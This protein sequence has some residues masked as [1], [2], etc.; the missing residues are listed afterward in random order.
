MIDQKANLSAGVSK[1]LETISSHD[2]IPRKKAKFLNFMT[3]S[4]RYMKKYDLEEAWQ[5]LEQAM[6]ESKETNSEADKPA[7][8]SPVEPVKN[9]KHK[10][11]EESPEPEDPKPPKKKKKSEEAPVEQ[12]ANT[13]EPSKKK[14][15]WTD[16]IRTII[17]AENNELKLKKL[18][19]KVIAKYKSL[20][21]FDW[22]DKME[23]KFNKKI[24]KIEGLTVSEEKVRLIA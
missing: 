2:N 23:N 10:L 21:G 7:L 16:T 17:T 15:R 14:F 12:E 5:L 6:K 24:G 11:L 22:T 4:F 8:A 18:K 13:T 20:T 1:I 3:N 9:G 19:K